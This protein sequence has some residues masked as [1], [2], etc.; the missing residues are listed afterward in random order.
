MYILY[1]DD[2]ILEVTYEEEL[3][4]IIDDIKAE[5]LDINE[6]INIEYSLVV[7]KEKVYSET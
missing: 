3:R 5:G 4:Q 2:Y 6:E 7:N 1:T